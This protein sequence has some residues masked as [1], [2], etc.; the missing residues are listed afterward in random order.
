M[1]TT[2]AT[3]TKPAAPTP[4]KPAQAAAPAPAKAPAK[5]P[6]GASKPPGKPAKGVAAGKAAKAPAKA[7]AKP[8]LAAPAGQAITALVKDSGAR[9][10]TIRDKLRRAVLTSKTTA[11]ALKKVVKHEGEE[12]PVT[13]TVLT[14]MVALKLIKLSKL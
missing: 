11:E 3:T 7:P 10:G 1:T 2:T 14:N 12:Y 5:A 4:G 8:P 6:G 13:Q 9:E